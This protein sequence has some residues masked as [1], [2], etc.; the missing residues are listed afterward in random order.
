VRNLLDNAERHARAR[1]TLTLREDAGEVV[2]TVTDDGP[3]I[4]EG[5]AGQVFERFARVDEARGRTEG[6]S[7]LGLAI[8]HDIVTRH[9]GVIRVDADHGPGA[10]FLVRLPARRGSESRSAPL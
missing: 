2:L 6:G 10:R 8:A 3:G 9:G 1:V 7:G 4:P 5:H